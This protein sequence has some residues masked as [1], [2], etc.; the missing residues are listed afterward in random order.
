[1]GE[2]TDCTA[3]VGEEK[4][5]EKDKSFGTRFN[6]LEER[7]RERGAAQVGGEK[8]SILI[9]APFLISSGT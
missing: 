6:S 9:A 4:E 8:V 5:E 7:E 3:E 2:H 1:M